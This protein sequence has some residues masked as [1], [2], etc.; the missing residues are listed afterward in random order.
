MKTTL[1]IATIL[2]LSTTSFAKPFQCNVIR[3]A[4]P[5]DV[6]AILAAKEVDVVIPTNEVLYSKDQT[7]VILA[8][9]PNGQMSLLV[10]DGNPSQTIAAAFANEAH[11]LGLWV[12]GLKIMVWCQPKN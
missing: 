7:L 9:S 5:G 11:D 10:N 12:P 4:F 2:L 3:P 1:F 8:Q 6:G